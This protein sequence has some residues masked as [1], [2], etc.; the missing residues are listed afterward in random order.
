MSPFD[1]LKVVCPT[2]NRP[3]TWVRSRFHL[4]FSTDALMVRRINVAIGNQDAHASGG[5]TGLQKVDNF[6]DRNWSMPR[7]RLP[8]TNPD[9][10]PRRRVSQS[11][12]TS[13]P[14]M[15]SRRC[16]VCQRATPSSFSSRSCFSRTI[17]SVTVDPAEHISRL[18]SCG[19]EMRLTS[20]AVITS[21]AFSPPLLAAESASTDATST[22]R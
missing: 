1:E 6:H 4:Q 19:L 15:R 13:E 14:L 12:F 8:S 10:V 5:S 9:M 16:P 17:V 3:A 2:S 7:L 18:K 21:R 20:T 22:H 11:T